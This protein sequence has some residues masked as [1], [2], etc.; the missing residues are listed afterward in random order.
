MHGKKDG[1]TDPWRVDGQTDGRTDVVCLYCYSYLFSFGPRLA[2][3]TS[4]T[5]CSLQQKTIDDI[6]YM[7]GNDYEA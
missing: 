5:R 1:R 6:Q 4:R 2:R 7:K 3:F